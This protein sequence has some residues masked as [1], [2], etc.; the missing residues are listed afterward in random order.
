MLI[1]L[2]SKKFW[3]SG[4]EVRSFHSRY[5]NS[6]LADAIMIGNID[7]VNEIIPLTKINANPKLRFGSYLHVAVKFGRLQIFKKIFALVKN[8]ENLKDSN[9]CN[10]HQ[11]LLDENYH[12][13]FIGKPRRQ[14]EAENQMEEAAKIK[15]EMLDFVNQRST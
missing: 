13:E 12:I 14:N 6:P 8:W 1:P 15:Q 11:L 3:N 2:T 10:V 5:Y 9:G 4:E 7:V